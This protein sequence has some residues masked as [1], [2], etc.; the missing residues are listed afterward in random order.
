MPTTSSIG[1]AG[2]RNYSTVAAWLAAFTTGGWIGQ[3]YNDSEFVISSAIAFSGQATSITDFIT[4]TTGPGQS[5]QDNASVQI[6]ALAYNV[7]N[8]VG[9]RSTAAYSPVISVAENYVTVSKL[10]L[11]QAGGGNEPVYDCDLASTN[12]VVVDSC[13]EECNS[14]STLSV[15]MHRQ[16]SGM[17]VNSVLINL[18]STG[19]G[20]SFDYATNP[21]VANCTI[22]RTSNNAAAGTALSAFSGSW[23]IQNSA[24]FGF[25]T[26]NSGG[27][28]TGN[29]NCSDLAI[30]F[31]SSNQAS[32]TYANQFKVTT[33]SG[34]DFRVKNSSAD[35]VD[36]GANL[37]SAY[38]L[39]SLGSSLDIALTTRPQGSAWDIGAWELVVAA[40]AAKG[41]NL[42]MMGMG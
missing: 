5:F 24:I 1:S 7:S 34:R 41:G 12:G 13:I 8:G 36:N 32:K 3:C 20:I 23:A 22:V 25:S 10:Q 17:V 28:V 21:V 35:V 39:T 30:G 37:S 9:I 18:G 15:G 16:R 38:P 26:L 42:L 2:G 40:A 27:S 6:N 31:G 11:Q 19:G 14:A 33:A 29:N 4:L